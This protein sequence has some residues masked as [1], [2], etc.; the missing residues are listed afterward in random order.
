M[1]FFKALHKGKCK[2]EPLDNLFQPIYTMTHLSLLQLYHERIEF[3]ITNAKNTNV[4]LY[5]IYVKGND[6]CHC[7]TCLTP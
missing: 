4:S 3:S 1:H 6:L 2:A 7:Q 5:D